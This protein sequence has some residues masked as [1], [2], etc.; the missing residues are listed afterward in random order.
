[1]LSSL[2]EQQTSAICC[3]AWIGL[4]GAAFTLPD[5]CSAQQ[6]SPPGQG[7]VRIAIVEG[8]DIRFRRLSNPQNLSHVR[9]ESIVQDT[10]GFMW[11]GTWNGLNRYDGYKFKVFKHEPGDPKSLSGVQV[12]SLFKDHSGHLW[13][14]TDGFLDRLH[15][16]TESF[17]HYK[18]DKPSTN[19]LSS[20]V[21]NISEDSSGKLWLSTRNGLFRFDPN[22]AELKNYVHAPADP[23][24][25][26]DND[27]QSTGEDREG[28]FCVATSRTVD[29][30]DKQTG[31]VKRHIPVGESGI[32]LW[33][34]EDRFGIFWV[35]YGSLGYIGTL[36][37]K[38]NRLTRYESESETGR[39][40]T[41]QAY[42][43]FEDS[44]GTMWFGTAAGLMKFDR[45]NRR[46]ISYRHDPDDPE[47]I[48]DNHVIVLFEDREGNIW[49]GLH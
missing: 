42:C 4:L 34:H 9:V 26:A 31:K 39:A 28:N 21:T 3:F 13:V 12:Y 33:F 2:A 22:S 29:E 32:G 47:T 41:N 49:A 44:K 36:D 20:I 15:P 27:V 30:F 35:I 37:R 40:Q 43:M 25:L 1:M 48:G 11:F 18:L 10:Q 14:G 16:E 19:R 7:I 8:R 5:H 23:L 45:R 38:T 17:T 24:A 46:F 6:A